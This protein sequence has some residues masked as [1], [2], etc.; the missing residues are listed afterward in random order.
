MRN[1]KRTGCD[2]RPRGQTAAAETAREHNPQ[3][4]QEGTKECYQT[5]HP[6]Q[7]Q[8]RTSRQCRRRPNYERLLRLHK[9]RSQC[10]PLTPQARST[11]SPK[12]GE[13]KKR[14]ELSTQR[15]RTAG[16]DEV[17]PDLTTNK[18][19]HPGVPQ[20]KRSHN[21][22]G[23]TSRHGAAPATISKSADAGEALRTQGKGLL[24]NQCHQR[25]SRAGR[26]YHKRCRK[27]NG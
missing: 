22:Y 1:N 7:S 26:R 11:P 2:K 21:P 18:A 4:Q 14:T 10:V 5:T 12:Q 3:E 20:T 17:N 25:S 9:Q 8:Q 16:G 6:R 15:R 24:P 23:R 19:L 27:P 13:T